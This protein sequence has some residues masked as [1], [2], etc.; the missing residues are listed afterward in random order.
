MYRKVKQG[1]TLKKYL[2][3]EKKRILKFAFSYTVFITFIWVLG[4]YL[5]YVQIRESRKWVDPSWANVPV[6]GTLLVF[7][8][9]FS[10]SLLLF[11]GLGWFRYRTENREE[12][13]L[14]SKIENTLRVREISK[15]QLGFIQKIKSSTLCQ[16]WLAAAVMGILWL[17]YIATH[18]PGVADWDT[19]WI[20]NNPL[21]AAEGHPLFYNE[22][23]YHS[24]YSVFESTGSFNKGLMFYSA[25]QTLLTLLMLWVALHY[26]YKITKNSLILWGTALFLGAYPI[27]PCYVMYISKDNLFSI[28]VVAVIPLGWILWKTRGRELQNWRFFTVA[29]LLF[30]LMGIT[31]NNGRYAVIVLLLIL[32]FYCFKYWKRFLPFALL[33]LFA[34]SSQ[35]LIVKHVYGMEQNFQ[36]SVA[37]PLQQL[38]AVI[39]TGGEINANDLAFLTEVAPLEVWHKY[40]PVKADAIKW[41]KNF[42][43]TYLN[44]KRGEFLAVWARTLPG[45]FA[46][47]VYSYLDLMAPIWMVE[48]PRAA[49]YPASVPVVIE[50]PK[51]KMVEK[52]PWWWP[53]RSGYNY[54]LL[55]ERAVKGMNML[56]E[57]T[58]GIGFWT[59]S[60]ILLVFCALFLRNGKRLIAGLPVYLVLGTLLVAIPLANLLRYS[61]FLIPSL[62]VLA[63]LVLAKQAD[64]GEDVQ[65]TKIEKLEQIK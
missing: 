22:L 44:E 31:R 43:R 12:N 26:L 34:V 21:N 47:Y 2:I 59:H 50:P 10:F 37:V 36:E 3:Q 29:L 23:L 28:A 17:P 1:R 15:P 63:G 62:P 4:R 39:N 35:N 42:N 58:P 33:V 55:G 60:H 61:Y 24:V 46:T 7:G 14:E 57:T 32:G 45:N 13:H 8:L 38:G 30:S 40:D 41:H 11:G 18:L 56:V 53:F 9:A 54:S 49:F 27:V 52:Y 6:G 20:L 48:T 64:F 65:V 25:I 51:P 5:N 16:S 19:W